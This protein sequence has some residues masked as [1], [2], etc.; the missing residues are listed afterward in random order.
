MCPEVSKIQAQYFR[1]TCI[2][3]VWV[4]GMELFAKEN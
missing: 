2:R 1:Q 4:S 3:S